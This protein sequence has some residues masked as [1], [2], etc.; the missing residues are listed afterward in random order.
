MSRLFWPMQLLGWGVPA[1]LFCVAMPVTTV[2]YRL[3]T[4]CLPSIYYP[5]LT[6]LGWL[7]AFGILALAL[8]VVTMICCLWIYL[9]DVVN[10]APMHGT[11]RSGRFGPGVSNTSSNGH[12]S[13]RR[14]S[15]TPTVRRA[16]WRR[17]R[18][19]L[20][21][22]WRSFVLAL[23]VSV[24]VVLY[25]ALFAAQEALTR[26]INNGTESSHIV[27]WATCLIVNDLDPNK[28]RGIPNVINEVAF[29]AIFI[30][31]AVSQTLEVLA[32][33]R[34]LTF[35][36]AQRHANLCSTGPP[37]HDHRLGVHHPPRPPP[38]HGRRILPYRADEA[39]NARAK[40]RIRQS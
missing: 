36:P 23:V 11:S 6:F 24:D 33:D 38:A 27:E 1:I 9:R 39:K 12:T 2:S 31:T 20:K 19:V 15:D 22:Q 30:L 8:Q 25:G 7:M 34:L 13:G 26:R 37:L 17:T 32:K 5:F 10:G 21:T 16:T 35:I 3:G 29:N 4:I 18:V 40:A 14:G 28:C